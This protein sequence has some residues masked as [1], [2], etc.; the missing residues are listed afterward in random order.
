MTDQLLNAVA[1]VRYRV[2]AWNL[3]LLREKLTKLNKRATKVGTAPIA[4]TDRFLET[5]TW[6]DE[7]GKDH[8]IAWH[9]V[10][11][12][13]AVAV[14]PGF[15]FLAAIHHTD[16]GNIL[17]KTP[18]AGELDAKWRTAPGFC[19]H[20]GVSRKRNSTYL[21]LDATG[22]LKQVGRQCLQDFTGHH[23]PF[24][25]ATWAEQIAALDAWLG[26]MDEDEVRRGSRV[27][28]AATLAAFL[29]VVATVIRL[30]GWTSRG[31]ERD[32]PSRTATATT[33]W[34]A[35]WASER[36]GRDLIRRY[37]DGATSDDR[38]L[39]ART[40]EWA[41]A[42]VD[43]EGL[44]DYLYNLSV[45]AR[46]SLVTHRTTG[47]AASM[48]SAYRREVER[49]ESAKREAARAP[50]AFVGTIGERLRGVRVTVRRRTDLEPNEFGPRT[51]VAM[52]D[53]SGN[54]L[55]W[56]TG[57][58]GVEV[59]DVRFLTGTVKSHSEYKGRKQTTLS[60]CVLD[61]EAPP[62]KAPKK[63]RGA[64]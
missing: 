27:D 32:D 52:E 20:C 58:S 1:P 56:F 26:G 5:T 42:L 59:G 14:V 48:V 17:A 63:K 28:P 41:R 35:Y 57:W 18:G 62:V 50:S 53:E 37:I 7:D 19:D 8:A 9:E 6:R 55:T 39:A 31:M 25:V 34:S 60:R 30:D 12:T 61:A 15:V 40:V 51:L 36:Y 43:A 33:A 24:A 38:A 3:D 21:L 64:A 10:F 29:T 54:D 16:D 23:D 2:P 47:L 44:N 11:L 13:G 46:A 49:A 45:V 22:A 4:M